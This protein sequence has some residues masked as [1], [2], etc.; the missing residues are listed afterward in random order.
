MC[1]EGFIGV[2]GDFSVPKVHVSLLYG[3]LERES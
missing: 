1:D 3:I 2:A